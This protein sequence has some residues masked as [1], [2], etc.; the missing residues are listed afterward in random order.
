MEM[1]KQAIT[2]IGITLG[3]TMLGAGQANAISFNIDTFNNQFSLPYD[4]NQTQTS[5]ANPLIQTGT[6]YLPTGTQSVPAFINDPSGLP[7]DQVLGGGRD[8]SL[9][10]VFNNNDLSTSGS[11]RVLVSG[12]TGVGFWQVASANA[13][14]VSSTTR[15]TADP[16]APSGAANSGRFKDRLNTGG[17]RFQ[18]REV[19]PGGTDPLFQPVFALTLTDSAGVTSRVQR[20]GIGSF[21]L[22]FVS[23]ADFLVA[24]N[25][26][27][28]LNEIRYVD[29]EVTTGGNNSSTVRVDFVE[30]F[31]VPE[32]STLLALAIAL[33]VGLLSTKGR[34]PSGEQN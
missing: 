30:G 11:S 26:L 29:L 21:Q 18:T 22:V 33:G 15:W 20:S 19:I 17:L 4:T 2:G 6:R 23:L 9:F 34:G 5:P 24:S 3:V 7:T 28:N 1:L 31:E 8:L 12:T 16:L 14:R 25:N 10:S 32:P 13:S 27:I